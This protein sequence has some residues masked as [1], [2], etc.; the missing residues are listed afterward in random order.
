MQQTFCSRIFKYRGEFVAG[1]V[2]SMANTDKYAVITGATGGIGAALAHRLSRDG[3]RLHLCDVD[4]DRLD[5]LRQSLPAETTVCE[6]RLE[7]P[8]ACSTALSGVG[9]PIA[10]LVHLAGI[11]EFHDLDDAGRDTY[12]RTMQHNVTNAFDLTS[13]AESDLSNNGRIVFA[14]SLAFRRG[15]ADN[16]SYSMAKGALVGL[17]RALSRRLAPR[18][19]LVNAVAPSLIQTA[20]L[21]QVMAG[22]DEQAMLEAVPLRRLG[23]PREVAGLIAFLL[24]DDASYITGQ[25]INVDGGI[26]NS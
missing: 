23:E 15:A 20:M 1:I 12:E 21:D 7:S 2:T 17:T 25:V 14:S 3:W 5:N 11:F 9:G 18:N 10:V 6:T 24:S 13:V 16:P 26:I 4:A 8:T 22:R 19:I